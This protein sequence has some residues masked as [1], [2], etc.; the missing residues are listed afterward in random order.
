MIRKIWWSLFAGSFAVALVGLR[1]GSP[2]TEIADAMF[3]VAVLLW[4][5]IGSAC[6]ASAREV[7]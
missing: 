6:Q 1:E 2:F 4:P 7:G 5:W 3:V